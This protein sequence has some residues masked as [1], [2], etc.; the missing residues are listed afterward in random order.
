MVF[1][2]SDYRVGNIQKVI[3]FNFDKY[4]QGIVE[5]FSC[6]QNDDILF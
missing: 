4:L 1:G 6:Q 2:E 3:V 5:I